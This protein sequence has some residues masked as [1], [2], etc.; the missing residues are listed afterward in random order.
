MKDFFPISNEYPNAPESALV[1]AYK[2]NKKKAA[3]TCRVYPRRI[4]YG[5]TER[6]S[7]MQWLME[8]FD[9]DKQQDR[10][11]ALKYIQSGFTSESLKNSD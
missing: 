7:E 4:F 9:F 6:H 8:A 1:F 11:F 5:S 10:I 2:T 3:L